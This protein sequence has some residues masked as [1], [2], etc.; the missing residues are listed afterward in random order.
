M[1]NSKILHLVRDVEGVKIRDF[2]PLIHG[3]RLALHTTVLLS[4]LYFQYQVEHFYGLDL[5]IPTYTLLALAFFANGVYLYFSDR[6]S[7]RPIPHWALFVFDV[8]LVSSLITLFGSHFSLFVFLYMV[9]VVLGGAAFQVSGGLAMACLVSVGYSLSLLLTEDILGLRLYLSLGLN[10]LAFF[11]IGYLSGRLSDDF[12]SMGHQL[13][14]TVQDFRRW[15]N[16]SD[17]VLEN[18]GTGLLVVDRHLV[19]QVS[20]PGARKIFQTDKLVGTSLATLLGDHEG[21]VE[22]WT[23]SH[24]EVLRREIRRIAPGEQVQ[25]LE[26]AATP[27]LDASKRRIGHILLV[28]DRTSQKDMERQLRQHEKMAAVGQLAA[29]IAH[30]IRNP[31]ASIS[32]SI[33]LLA[34]G[35]ATSAIESA[36]LMKI[37]VRE[38]DRLNDLITEFLDYVKPEDLQLVPVDLDDLIK[39]I[40]EAIRFNSRIRQDVT[41]HRG[42][43]CAT[44]VLAHRDKLKQALLNILI[45]AFQAV[46][47]SVHPQ[48]RIETK[49]Q[50]GCAVLIVEDNGVGIKAEDLDRIFNPFHTTKPQGTGL[51][52][53]M[54]QKILK[55]HHAKILVE[56]REGE[57]TKFL[58]ELPTQTEVYEGGAPLRRIG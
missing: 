43:D 39:E 15:K 25:D 16:L 46:E 24:T 57:G 4:V 20:N 17:L 1:D 56:S 22:D 50:P 44:P 52:L 37:A 6:L 45:N 40:L 10:N 31:L 32:G 19:V 3:T 49:D 30:E 9:L 8:V 54:T 53:A 7:D 48:I 36:R 21:R 55:A 41:L 38:I 5:L 58:I 51:G 23:A 29:G 47:K 14:E 28:D 12:R 18:I 11:S 42:L 33:Q 2:W 35:D 13:H 26:V 34:S 27:L